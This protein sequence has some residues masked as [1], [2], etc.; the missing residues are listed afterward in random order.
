MGLKRLDGNDPQ[1][2]LG[3]TE[4]Q[5]RGRREEREEDKQPLGPG[6]WA[7]SS[8]SMWGRWDTLKLPHGSQGPA[9]F[10]LQSPSSYPPV[11][12]HFWS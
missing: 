9:V 10:A 12:V 3:R 1:E 8:R 6:Q 4:K 7:L 5:S 11:G 2:A